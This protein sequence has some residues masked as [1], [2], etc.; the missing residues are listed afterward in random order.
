MNFFT[1]APDDIA[2]APRAW[3]FFVSQAHLFQNWN[4]P[5]R[6]S[7]DDP[8][9]DCLLLGELLVSFFDWSVKHKPTDA[10]A[11]SVHGLLSVLLPNDDKLPGWSKLKA[12]LEQVYN[13]C[14]IEVHLC[15]ND[16]MSFFDCDHPELAHYRHS[17]RTKC[18]H[19][20]AGRYVEDS[21]GVKKAAKVGYYFPLDTWMVS[22]FKNPALRPHLEFDVGKH[23]SGHVSFSK[24]WYDKVINNPHINAE[25]RNQT[26]IG[27]SDG[28][29]LFKDKNSRSVVP[30]TLRLGNLPDGISKRCLLL[31]VV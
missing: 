7:P 2:D 20:G 6:G 4:I 31:S 14:V 12:L 26:V 19:C 22:T 18:L 11:K 5:V 8:E 28:I 13:N 23:P 27:M 16:C 3:D 17:H 30:I 10:S 9:S 25:S 21:D 29:P 15:P 24:G 1:Q